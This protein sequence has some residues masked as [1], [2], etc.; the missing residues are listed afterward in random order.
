MACNKDSFERM[1][2]SVLVMIPLTL[3]GGLQDAYSYFVRDRVFANAQTGNI[4]LMSHELVSGNFGG[5]LRYL[6]PV[7]AFALGVLAAGVIC[8]FHPGGSR[9]HWRQM[10][11]AGEVIL[12]AMVGLMPGE[13]NWLANALTSFSC[14]MQVQSF[15]SVEG[16]AYASTMCIGNLRSGMAHLSAALCRRDR[17]Q[18]L[19]AGKYGAIILLFA[20][21][22][23]MGSVLTRYMGLRTIWVSCGLLMAGC[24]LMGLG[25]GPADRVS[26]P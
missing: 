17:T 15:R 16:S 25:G 21:G 1:S 23:G 22:G 26:R 6:I 10:V 11:L 9:I 3:S 7:L 24:L 18:L 8:S 12:L 14:A 20:I 2:D 19:E 13:W 4:I 5:C